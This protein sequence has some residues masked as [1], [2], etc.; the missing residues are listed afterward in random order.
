MYFGVDDVDE[1]L[2]KVGELGGTT[3]L[4]A[5]DIEIAKI[6]VVSDPQGAVFAIYAG[7]MEP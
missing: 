7:M 3:L 5:T 1:A 4:G 2:A 6:A